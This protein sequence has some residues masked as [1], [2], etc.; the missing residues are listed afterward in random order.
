VAS[1][2]NREIEAMLR[3][4]ITSL[5]IAKKFRAIEN[6][7]DDAPRKAVDYK[8]V[9]RLEKKT[10]TVPAVSRNRNVPISKNINSEKFDFVMKDGEEGG[11]VVVV[12]NGEANF[13]HLMQ[14]EELYEEVVIEDPTQEIVFIANQV[15][16]QLNVHAIY[17]IMAIQ[18][19]KVILLF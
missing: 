18:T 11:V 2:V 1:E 17:F 4:G 14:P 19:S 16:I 9:Y 7:P 5:Q 6:K 15:S 13:V 3:S 8:H 10:T 12:D